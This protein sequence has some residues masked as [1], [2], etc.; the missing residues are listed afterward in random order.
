M[1]N[2]EVGHG[3]IGAQ[4][5]W[6]SNHSLCIVVPQGDGCLDVAIYDAEIG[7]MVRSK[8]TSTSFHHLIQPQ[9]C[10]NKQMLAWRDS[11]GDKLNI[12]NIDHEDLQQISLDDPGESPLSLAFSKNA[13][14][15]ISWSKT[16][17]QVQ[18]WDTVDE[19]NNYAFSKTKGEDMF[20]FLD[21]TTILSALDDTIYFT[22][23]DGEKHKTVRLESKI[24]DDIK[25][26]SA[27]DTRFLT[28]AVDTVDVNSTWTAQLWNA[29][30]GECIWAFPIKS[31]SIAM[32]G[33]LITSSDGYMC[34]LFA[35]GSSGT[36][37]SETWTV[38]GP[39][40]I[41]DDQDSITLRTIDAEENTTVTSVASQEFDHLWCFSS[42]GQY[43]FTSS[44]ISNRLAVIDA[45]RGV[46]CRVFNFVRGEIVSMAPCPYGRY[47]AVTVWFD[48]V[49]STKIWSLFDEL[50]S[51]EVHDAPERISNLVFRP[52]ERKQ[53]RFIENA[54]DGSLGSWDTDT[55][56]YT[57]WGTIQTLVD[58]ELSH[59][60]HGPN[61]TI[62]YSGQM[63]AIY[64]LER[65]LEIWEER[66]GAKH[67]KIHSHQHVVDV[68]STAFSKDGTIL[69]A[70]QLG[71]PAIILIYLDTDSSVVMP[72]GNREYLSAI[73]FLSGDDSIAITG[74]DLISI[75]DLKGVLIGA[76]SYDGEI[77]QA[78]ESAVLG[79][80]ELLVSADRFHLRIWNVTDP[81]SITLAHQLNMDNS[82]I[83]RILHRSA[84]PF[85]F[86]TNLGI[87]DLSPT[88]NAET[89]DNISIHSFMVGFG[90]AD[91][92]SWVAK[93]GKRVLWLPPG[94][95]PS[96]Q[97][98]IVVTESSVAIGRGYGALT[99]LN[100]DL[101]RSV[102]AELT[103]LGGE[104]GVGET[105]ESDAQNKES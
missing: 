59:F 49:Y 79:D 89:L 44:T 29:N 46:I 36:N 9:I 91:D 42:S 83:D 14:Y 69:A 97:R 56:L 60:W 72:I 93:D 45:S 28:F 3:V 41:G 55:S 70:L 105:A 57:F 102:L 78:L 85:T 81:T 96:R 75:Y 33:R 66:N 13:R 73:T 100:F 24:I 76:T 65:N 30:R 12:L 20:C 25:T 92:D 99:I 63:V 87:L 10:S 54:I 50:G 32:V 2:I 61:I 84:K 35:H 98:E 17:S 15:L 5:F 4:C 71:M 47:L 27:N 90:L 74:F 80:E 53:S 6:G 26:F 48:S 19:S 23:M 11:T 40:Q 103:G 43:L 86:Y 38:P 8:R 95:R 58:H 18:V 37:K 51:H 39:K 7:A 67:I 88:F 31:K 77:I 1:L 68:Q 62:S 52:S 16:S 64:G 34:A 104:A 22:G 82:A 101:D 94:N 21:A